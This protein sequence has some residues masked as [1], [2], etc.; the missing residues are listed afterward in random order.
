VLLLLLVTLLGDLE[1]GDQFGESLR[2]EGN[3]GYW[4]DW[5]ILKLLGLSTAL[6]LG[7]E[8]RWRHELPNGEEDFASVDLTDKLI[9]EEDRDILHAQPSDLDLEGVW[10]LCHPCSLPV[11]GLDCLV[12]EAGRTFWQPPVS[13]AP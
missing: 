2:G 12:P 1:D 4:L 13:R 8:Q 6:F 11:I 5:D 7:S 3:A 9:R 10:L